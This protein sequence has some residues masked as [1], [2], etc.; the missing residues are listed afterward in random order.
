MTEIYIGIDPGKSGGMCALIKTSDI[1]GATVAELVPFKSVEETAKLIKSLYY[2][3]TQK[4]TALIEN[5][6]A[7]PTDGRS[8]AF[9]FGVNFGQWQGILY[10]N[11][12]NVEFIV[13]FKWMS[14]YRQFS[15]DKQERK[16]Q[17][18]ELAND[19]LPIYRCDKKATLKTADAVLIANYLY[20]QKMEEKNGK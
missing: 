9:K 4:V 18:K 2:S 20:E 14:S 19:L 3:N 10:S 6:H 5:V 12:I 7:F 16:N 13:P 17:I 11:N 15:K 8:S 1:I